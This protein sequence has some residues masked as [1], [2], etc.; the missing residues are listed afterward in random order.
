M[1]SWEE[2]GS[3]RCKFKSRTAHPPIILLGLED[4]VDPAV[5]L[6]ID[7]DLGMS[8]ARARVSR[9]EGRMVITGVVPSSDRGISRGE[10][11]ATGSGKP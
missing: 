8:M 1:I 9:L 3:R 10:S 5:D 6:F 2:M 7:V 4:H 11:W